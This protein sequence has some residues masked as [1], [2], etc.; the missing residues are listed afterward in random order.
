MIK[1]HLGVLSVVQELN[2][3]S[4]LEISFP[5]KFKNNIYSEKAILTYGRGFFKEYKRAS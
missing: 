2:K 4:N 5:V 3:R 1:E